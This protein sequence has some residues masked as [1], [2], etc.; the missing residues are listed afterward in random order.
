MGALSGARANSTGLEALLHAY[1][2][3][4]ATHYRHPGVATIYESNQTKLFT[5]PFFA[6]TAGTLEGFLLDR[7]F[8]GNITFDS[9]FL[10]QVPDAL[11]IPFPL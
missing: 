7:W 10:E 1:N 4:H 5:A 3:P 11:V 9:L 8:S 6:P 2:Q